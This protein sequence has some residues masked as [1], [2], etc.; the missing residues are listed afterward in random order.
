ENE[1]MQAIQV[2]EQNHLDISTQSQTIKSLLLHLIQ[3]GG[4]QNEHIQQL[5]HFINGLQLQTLTETN[6]ML[7]AQLYL[8]GSSFALND[9][10]EERRVGKEGRAWERQYD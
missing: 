4:Q 7:Q 8:P 5:V 1:M 3:Q 9:R 2:A 10:S 6:Q